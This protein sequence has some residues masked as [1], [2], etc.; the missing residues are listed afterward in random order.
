MRSGAATAAT[1]MS[2]RPGTSKPKKDEKFKFPIALINED[3]SKIKDFIEIPKYQNPR[4]Q[5]AETYSNFYAPVRDESKR[6][7]SANRIIDTRP[8]R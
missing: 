3:Y 8:Q 2:E 6:C 7:K 4:R 1:E 5:M